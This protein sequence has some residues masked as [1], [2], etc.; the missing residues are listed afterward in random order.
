MSI[1]DKK[2][3]SGDEIGVGIALGVASG[4]DHGGYSGDFQKGIT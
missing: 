1:L 4:S 3:R 2:I